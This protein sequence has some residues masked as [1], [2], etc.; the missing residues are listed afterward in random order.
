MAHLFCS[1]CGSKNIYTLSKPK[2]CQ[3]CG[4]QFGMTAPMKR[5]AASVTV[6]QDEQSEYV[7]QISKLQYEINVG[8]NNLDLGS[9]INNPMN[10]SDMNYNEGSID[11]KPM[12]REEYLNLSTSECASS[13][14]AK[15][16]EGE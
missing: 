11:Y 14:T 9:L 7:P 2:F 5:S 16:I 8:K 13:K 3:S 6:T 4:N 1:E 12:S 15:H 10:P